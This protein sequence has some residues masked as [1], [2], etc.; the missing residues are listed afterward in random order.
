MR[1]QHGADPATAA[2]P[3]PGVTEDRRRG[4]GG[5]PWTHTGGRPDHDAP[6]PRIK[7]GDIPEILA[8]EFP[9]RD[10]LT[11]YVGSNAATPTASL[12][13]ITAGEKALAVASIAHPRFRDEYLKAI[14]DDPMF[15]KPLRCPSRKLPR[16]VTLYQGPIPLDD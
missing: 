16:G 6:A 1:R 15:T 10:T 13:A 4:A 7:L 14:S 9:A 5:A 12:D 11:V 2:G 8:R 3:A